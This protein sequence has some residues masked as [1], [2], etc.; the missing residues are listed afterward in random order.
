MHADFYVKIT[1]CRY[2]FIKRAFENRKSKQR[3]RNQRREPTSVVVNLV[4][5]SL[6]VL[7]YHARRRFVTVTLSPSSEC[8]RMHPYVTPITYYNSLNFIDGPSVASVLT[9]LKSNVGINEPLG[10]L[11]GDVFLEERTEILPRLQA[12]ISMSVT[13]SGHRQ[14][15][16]FFCYFTLRYIF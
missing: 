6:C 3:C 1:R 9:I 8:D 14:E 12:N 10:N 15:K 16:W 11:R 7:R 4:R 13:A 5:N 2:F